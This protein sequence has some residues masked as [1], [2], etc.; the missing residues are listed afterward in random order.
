MTTNT[1]TARV[2]RA[3]IAAFT[4]HS[5]RD[6]RELTKNARH[7]FMGRFLAEIPADLPEDERL[8]RAKSA[9]RAY[10]ARLSLRSVEARRKRGRRQEAAR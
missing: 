6:G 7:K 8:R 9:K 2:L 5:K 4:L 10:F 3:K 1:D